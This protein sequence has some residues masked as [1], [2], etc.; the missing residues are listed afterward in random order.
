M[1][2]RQARRSQVDQPVRKGRKMRVIS[3]LLAVILT[4]ALVLGLVLPFVVG[5]GSEGRAVP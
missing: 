3:I 1:S 4:T 2:R 5:G